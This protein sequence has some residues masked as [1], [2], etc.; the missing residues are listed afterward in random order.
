MFA[1]IKMPRKIPTFSN[2]GERVGYFL[3][4]R[5]PPTEREQ[6]NTHTH[7]DRNSGERPSGC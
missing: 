2:V 6:K 7:T 1:S 3:H 5:E 4:V